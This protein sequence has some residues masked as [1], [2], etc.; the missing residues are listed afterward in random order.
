MQDLKAR[1]ITCTSCEF[2]NPPGVRFCGRCGAAL[3]SLCPACGAENPPGFRF[4]GQCGASLDTPRAGPATAEERG[5]SVLLD[6]LIEIVEEIG[7]VVEELAAKEV[8][9]TPG[10]TSP[11]GRQNQGPTGTVEEPVRA[12]ALEDLIE[13]VEEEQPAEG[14]L[15]EDIEKTADRQPEAQTGDPIEERAPA[16]L[17]CTVCGAD[18]PPTAL[19]CEVCGAV[20]APAGAPC[21]ACGRLNERGSLFCETCGERLG[22]DEL[23]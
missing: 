18:N 6:D 19:Y 16:W 23:L 13:I 21:P 15:P 3:L 12:P 11:T 4:C 10:G 8:E 1:L 14:G 7:P 5:S 2:E 20:V 9:A 17:T 22:L